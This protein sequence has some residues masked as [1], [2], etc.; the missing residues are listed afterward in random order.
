MAESAL[1]I[2]LIEL[3][4]VISQL[5][6][7]I[8]QYV[9]LISELNQT[10]TKLNQTNAELNEEN[11]TL[12]KVIYGSSREKT[13]FTPED[14]AQLSL[15]SNQDAIEEPPELD[16]DEFIEVSYKRRKRPALKEQFENIP[17]KTVVIDNLS[18]EEK[19]CYFCGT[20]MEP[21]GKEVLHR[22]V[23]H[24][25][26]E[27]YMVEYVG[28]NYGCP[29]CKE[30]EAPYIVKNT[31]APK[32]LIKGSY[33]SPSLA[34][35][36]F[37]QKFA[38]SVPFYRQEKSMEELGARITRASMANWAITLHG[39]HLSY[40]SEFFHRKLLE[41]SFIMM[42]ETPI[43]V[44]EEPGR[45]AQTKSYVWLMRSGED[46]LPPIVFYHYAPSRAGYVAR[47][48]TDGIEEGTYGMMDGYG[49][50]NSL[51][52]IKRCTCYAH[53]R[54]YFYE[55]IPANK[56]DDFNEPAVQGVM[57]CDKLFEYERRY[58]AQGLTYEQRRKRR[59]KD[60]KPV[61]EAFLEW[62]EAH[63][64]KTQG[65]SR[66]ARAIKYV[67]NRKQDM[68]TYLEDG[69]CSLSNNASERNCRTVAVGRKNWLFC[70]SVQGAEATMTMLTIVEMAKQHKI[71]SYEYIKFLLE[72]R[73][74][75]TWTDDQL[76]LIAPWNEEV[77]RICKRGSNEIDE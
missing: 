46:G 19:N 48:L 55:A 27:L 42:D 77:Q 68:M 37:Y 72:K 2:Q 43:Q 59:L 18:D 8:A 30:T 76:E 31:D 58:K 53:I 22:E 54:R 57:Y 9:A 1:E 24:V 35:W 40:V 28:V 44:L 50:Y 67:I 11:A 51:K 64:L 17:V 63:A 6:T 5:N 47:E 74:D 56:K 65:N 33:V 13:K 29:K 10:I 45:R 14:S 73:P 70:Q 39:N 34:A 20:R 23:I 38:M 52:N 71:S 15:F 61:V 49:G 36:V 60:E 25:K 62:A 69:R 7:T 21:I 26:P 3:K 16:G 75:E 12:K 66:F 32:P 4:D 41:R